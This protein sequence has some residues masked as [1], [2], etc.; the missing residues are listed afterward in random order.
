M[1]RQGIDL[2]LDAL[3]EYD[4]TNIFG[5][6][7][8]SESAITNALASDKYKDF[9]YYLAVQEGVAMGMADGWA[10][11]SGK[12]A[13]V[14]LHIDSG[15][16]NGISLLI[17]AFYGG[18]PLVLTAGNKDIRKLNSYRSNLVNMVKEFTKWS[19]EVTHIDQLPEMTMRAFKEASTTPTAPVFLSISTNVFDE[20]TES[21]IVKLPY[22]SNSINPPKDSVELLTKKILDSENPLLLIGDRV[23]HSKSHSEVVKFA[24]ISGCSVYSST[25]SE[26]NF[27][28]D[29]PQYFGTLPNL[30]SKAKE[31]VDKHDLII[32]VGSNVFDGFF[33]MQGQLFNN[34]SFHAHID[35]SV[36]AIARNEKTDLGI[37][38]DPKSALTELNSNLNNSINGET[39]EKISIRKKELQDKTTIISLNESKLIS[40]NL[41]NQPMSAYEMFSEIFKSLSDF[42]VIDD[43][44]SSRSALLATNKFMP[45][46]MHGERGGAIGWGMGATM[47]VKLAN[48]NKNVI[49]I[50][51][52][53]SAMMT[54]QALW[55]AANSDI[56]VIY[57]ICNNH[58]YRVLKTNMQ[59]YKKEILN[60]VEENNKYFAMD[61]EPPFNFAEIAK[62][63][64]LNGYKITKPSEINEYINKAV[65]SNKTSVLDIDIDG[66]V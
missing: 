16:A 10:R 19:G 35:S 57:I 65:N 61:F 20:Y 62:T 23:S 47:G 52:D 60:D 3:K 34:N 42:I 44:V 33:Y 45:N 64:G 51:G 55:T 54:V 15:L 6:P 2:F 24:E 9:N 18:A 32:S 50:I 7:G 29:H 53:G 11:S 41:N 1:K 31:V 21:E 28:M 30:L 39:K 25:T 66:S 22:I 48:P 40:A 13:F 63:F 38:S 5:N 14:N 4:V 17:N 43:S 12:T 36:S 37:I 46:Q 49:G 58:S 27:P 59:I 26:I 8:T 56:P